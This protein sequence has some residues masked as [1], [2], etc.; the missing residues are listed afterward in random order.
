[1]TATA[2]KDCRHGK[3]LYLRRDLYVGRSLDIYGE[4]SELEAKIFEQMVG[5]NHVVIEVGANIGAHT[6]HL[7]KLVGPQGSVIAFEPQ[8]VIFQML[9]ANVA[10]NELFNVQTFHA[11]AGQHMG[12]LKLPPLDY[13]AEENFGGVSLNSEAMGEDVTVMALDVL[14]LSS[15][16]L[17]KIDAEGMESAVLEGAR[18]LIAKHRPFLYVENDR[19]DKSADLIRLI[20]AL[21]YRMWWHLP[22]LFNPDNFFQYPDNIFGGTVSANLLCLPMEVTLVMEGF[23]EVSGPDDWWL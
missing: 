13:A 10:M 6:V 23:Q 5:P 21:G 15:L 12:I 16:H 9:C 11:A 3:M 14:P 1:M 22:R 8:R 19:K 4:F 18:R 17:I 7:A 2:I 20:E